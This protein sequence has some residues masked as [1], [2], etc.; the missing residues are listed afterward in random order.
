MAILFTAFTLSGFAG[1][2]YESVWTHYLKLLLGHAAYAQTLVLSIFMGGLAIGAALTTLRKGRIGSPLKWYALVELILGVIAIQFHFIFVAAESSLHEALIPALDSPFLIETLRWS[3][4]VMLILPQ[5]I[6]LGTTFPLIGMAVVRLDAGNAGRSLGMLYFSNSIGGALGV[7]ASAFLLIDLLGLPGTMLSAGL[8]NVLVAGVVWVLSQRPVGERTLQALEGGD[9]ARKL[10]TGTRVLLAVALF[11]GVA[12]FFYEIAWIRMLSLVLGS[13]MQAFEMMLSAFITGLAL[14]G[15]WIRRWMQ[16]VENPLRLLGGIQL[17]MGLC[18]ALTIP[19]YGKMFELMSFLLQ[20]LALNDGGY[21]LF[22]LGSHGIA[23]L[24][25]LPA[26]ILAGMT[27]PLISYILIHRGQG[28]TSI[29]KVYAANTLGA[30]VGVLCAVHLALPLIGTRGL[31]LA[32]AVI[33]LIVGYVLLMRYREKV[34][35]LNLASAVYMAPLLVVVALAALA[36]FDQ[37]LLSSG[38]FRYGELINPEKETVLFYEDGKTASISMIEM[39]DGAKAILT[40]GK[41]DAAINPPNMPYSSDEITMVMAGVLPLAV[42]PAAKQIANIGLGSGMTTHTLLLSPDIERVDTIEIEPTVSR[43]IRLFGDTTALALSDPRSHIVYDDARSFFSRNRARYD[44]IVSEPSNPWVSGVAGL[45]ST[46]FYQH[47]SGHLMPDGIFVQW[48]HLYESNMDLVTSVF[49]ALSPHFA[50][51]AVYNSATDDIIIVASNGRDPSQ[52][53]AAVLDSPRLRHAMSRVRLVSVDDL[54]AR[55]IGTKDLLQPYFDATR[56]P[57]NSDFYPRLGLHATRARFLQE[58]ATA[59]SSL[60]LAPFPS[61][62]LFTAPGQNAATGL[63]FEG[64][65]ARRLARQV[66]AMLLNQEVDRFAIAPHARG[67]FLDL[68]EKVV[69]VRSAMGDCGAVNSEV[70]LSSL[71][72]I[73]LRTTPFLSNGAWTDF[74][75]EF[76]Q[77]PCLAAWPEDVALRIALY[78]AIV[79]RDDLATIR[80]AAILYEREEFAASPLAEYLLAARL[81]AYVRSGQTEAG[82]ELAYG[83]LARLESAPDFPLYLKILFA[84]LGIEG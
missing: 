73:V 22:N 25:M 45:F 65:V 84:Q 38:V 3:L 30:I 69:V 43:A 21:L 83:H 49:N 15:L 64:D 82:Q 72:S 34:P 7:L 71:H 74:W 46:E 79:R 51:Y 44:I 29:G 11:T 10:D 4:G 28:D 35:R 9:D 6:L 75:G 81:H 20:S 33:D 23:L 59:L 12:S 57:A 60:H 27:L 80:L 1:L 48:L 17:A 26:T 70:M 58:S 47:V 53:S 37:V 67:I 8:L 56:I 40:N 61:T 5:S 19:L 63:H 52:L 66:Q 76:E 55:R 32:G 42:H 77:H 62:Q 50:D 18:A 68:Q 41:P 14:G 39:E 16:R 78:G 36:R 54:A 31:L 2:I 13:S 24:I